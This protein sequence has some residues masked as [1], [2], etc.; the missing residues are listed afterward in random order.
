MSAAAAQERSWAGVRAVMSWWISLRRRAHSSCRAVSEVCKLLE[1]VVLVEE[2]AEVE[3]ED[4]DVG[5]DIL[6]L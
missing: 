1:A 3:H 6:C 4:M 5:G 2:E